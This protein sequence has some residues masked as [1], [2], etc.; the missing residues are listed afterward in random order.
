MPIKCVQP[1]Q[2]SGGDKWLV[3]ISWLMCYGICMPK[4]NHDINIRIDKSVHR[5]LRKLCRVRK[6]TLK[7][8]INVLSIHA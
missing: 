1:A 3:A 5:R 8:L 2:G 7:E 4:K 6:L